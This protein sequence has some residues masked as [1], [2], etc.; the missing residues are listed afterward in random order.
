MC[1]GSR[2]AVYGTAV[3]WS[4]DLLKPF[5]RVYTFLHY[6]RGCRPITKKIYDVPSAGRPAPRSGRF[7]CRADTQNTQACFDVEGGQ[8]LATQS[9]LRNGR[10]NDFQTPVRRQSESSTRNPQIR[11]DRLFWRTRTLWR[12][13]G[14]VLGETEADQG[15][16]DGVLLFIVHTG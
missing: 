1:G 11:E 7:G 4:F 16:L 9:T 14:D 3:P 8:I 2:C 12:V 5:R 6:V 15:T 10:L 13:R